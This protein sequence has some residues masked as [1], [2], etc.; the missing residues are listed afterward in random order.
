[1]TQNLNLKQCHIHS[2]NIGLL[3]LQSNNDTLETKYCQ[4]NCERIQVSSL[5]LVLLCLSLLSFH[6]WCY[7]NRKFYFVM[8]QYDVAESNNVAQSL[9]TLLGGPRRRM[10]TLMFAYHNSDVSA[11]LLREPW[12][13]F[14][15]ISVLWMSKIK[16]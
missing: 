13:W 1:M 16:K 7:L 9:G 4:R 8:Y 2:K 3:T 5:V 11:A 10:T 12:C 15:W 6:L 14:D